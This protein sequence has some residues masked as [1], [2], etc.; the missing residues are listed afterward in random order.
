MCGIAG[1]ICQM[2]I[3]KD[4]FEKMVDI[5]AHRGSGDR[6]TYYAHGIALGHRRMSIID[7]SMDGHS[8]FYTCH[9]RCG[10]TWHMDLIRNIMS[11]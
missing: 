5:V 9:F 8:R 6:G 1:C 2:D 7:L 3:N 4:K 10:L 11:L